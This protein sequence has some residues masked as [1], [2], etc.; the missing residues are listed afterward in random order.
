MAQTGNLSEIRSNSANRPRKR[1]EEQFAAAE[2]HSRRVRFLK[3][4]F[5]L[6]AITGAGLLA[7][8]TILR[9]QAAIDISTDSVSLS[10]GRIVMANP[11][12]DGLTGDK[13]PYAM[14][15]DRAFQEVGRDGLVE[16]EKI[17][18]ELPFGTNSTAQLRAGG[19][20]F[21]NTRNLLDLGKAIEM[22]TSDGMTAKLS[23]ARIDIAKN[24]LNTD[25]PVD[26]STNGS[27]IT[28]GKLSVSEGGKLLV[29][30]KNVRLTID[31]KK[32]N[33]ASGLPVPETTQ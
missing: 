4:A 9:P 13:R 33:N 10:D 15:A 7:A 11:K 25:E 18:A 2:R 8:A 17:T 23:S 27:R 29:F 12:L 24:A 31:P 16:L 28:A 26:I 1:V 20:F 3:V 5:P 21:D 6:A 19:G 22:T 14:R 32:L 30:E